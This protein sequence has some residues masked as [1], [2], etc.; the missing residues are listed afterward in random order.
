MSLVYVVQGRYPAWGS[1]KWDDE[2]EEET[3]KAGEQS[4]REYR[5]NGQGEYRLI[6]RRVPSIKNNG[7][8]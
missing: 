2:N 8:K 3:R 4:L 7:S 1:R 5:A 6:K